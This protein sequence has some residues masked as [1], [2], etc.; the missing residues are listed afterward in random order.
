VTGFL[1][2]GGFFRQASKL[3]RLKA[4]A[5][6]ADIAVDAES[7]NEKYN[8]K[9]QIDRYRKIEKEFASFRSQKVQNVIRELSLLGTWSKKQEDEWQI[10]KHELPGLNLA[11]DKSPFVCPVGNKI[12]ISSFFGDNSRLLGA[13]IR[14]SSVL[15]DQ[16]RFEEASLLT[17]VFAKQLLFR[18]STA[19]RI[20]HHI[21]TLKDSERFVHLLL[22]INKDHPEF[23]QQNTSIITLLTQLEEPNDYGRLTESVIVTDVINYNSK[24]AVSDVRE[25][26]FEEP[27]RRMWALTLPIGRNAL[28]A[29]YLEATLSGLKSKR[30]DS[31]NPNTYESTMKNVV[32][33]F[34]RF[35]PFFDPMMDDLGPILGFTSKLE[36]VHRDLKLSLRKLK[37][38]L[39][40]P[41]NMTP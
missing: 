3:D 13:T 2:W 9:G 20:S 10:L 5:K 15:V 32:P 12:E 11:L 22:K 4:E 17:E 29:T 31:F 36:A 23:L 25:L 8:R 37:T 14:V 39:R 28:T 19:F 30:S 38:Q 40:T 7:F 33:H 1:S 16:G 35:L 18:R 41:A 24:L 34:E 21:L 26:G 6:A 27:Y